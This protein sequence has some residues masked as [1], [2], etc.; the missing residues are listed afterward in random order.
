MCESG[1]AIVG[2]FRKAGGARAR[3]VFRAGNVLVASAAKE[4][5]PVCALDAGRDSGAPME[6]LLGNGS[7]R[8]MI[9]LSLFERLNPKLLEPLLYAGSPGAGQGKRGREEELKTFFSLT[10]TP[11]NL[12]RGNLVKRFGWR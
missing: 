1:A 11:R 8:L 4:H 7:R 3:S 9:S 5:L 2:S 10:L 12:L 6:H